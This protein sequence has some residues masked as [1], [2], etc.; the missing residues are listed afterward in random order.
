MIGLGV[1]P[2]KKVIVNRSVGGDHI[3]SN[4]CLLLLNVQERANCIPK[5]REWVIVNRDSVVD[6]LLRRTSKIC[7]DI[8]THNIN[9]Q[10]NK[11]SS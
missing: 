2:W 1:N 5:V 8:T 6:M 4:R 3:T 11:P 7:Y 10:I 9:K